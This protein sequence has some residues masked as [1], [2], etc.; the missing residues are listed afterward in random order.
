MVK[1]KSIPKTDL[2]FVEFYAEELKNNNDLFSQ[3]K[4]IIDSQI[5]ASLSLFSNMFGTKNFKK[6]SKRL[7]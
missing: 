5:K 1:L 3:Q 2:D 4:V 6:K 7:S